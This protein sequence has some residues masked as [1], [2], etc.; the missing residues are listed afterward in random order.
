MVKVVNFTGYSNEAFNRRGEIIS[1]LEVDESINQRPS[2]RLLESLR[3]GFA[4][5]PNSKRASWMR[6]GRFTKTNRTDS[7]KTM[8]KQTIAKI[9]VADENFQDGAIRAF[10]EDGAV[11]LSNLESLKGSLQSW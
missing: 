3:D 1:P 7:H 2:K 5:D 11:I 6:M 10:R 9:S 8:A 4:S